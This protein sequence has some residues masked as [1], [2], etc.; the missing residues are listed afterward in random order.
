MNRCSILCIALVTLTLTMPL[1]A[2]RKVIDGRLIQ[3]D[4]VAEMPPHEHFRLG[5]EA[6]DHQNWEVAANQ[7]HVIASNFPHSTYGQDANYYLGVALYNLSEFDLANDSLNQYLSC[8]TNPRFFQEAVEYKFFVAEQ[9]RCGARRHFLGTKQLPK[10]ASGKKMAIDIYDEVIA[11]LPSHEIAAKALFSKACLLW[12]QNDYR[13]SVEAFQTVIRR[14]PK[15][16]LAP[17]SY[18]LVNKIY[19]EQCQ[20]EY[21]NPDLLAFSQ[22]NLRRFEEDFPREER[23]VEARRDVLTIKEKYAKGLYDIGQFYER[24]YQPNAAVIYYQKAM[25]DFPDTTISQI[26]RNRLSRLCPSI[27]ENEEIE[28]VQKEPAT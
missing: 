25:L 28:C 9:F 20:R 10:W 21:Q 24:V 26:C 16:E 1:E 13:D 3:E 6:L 27:F 15:H 7:F 14:F 12:H 18:L 19:L 2:S 23:L 4:N 22:I 11:A 5:K 8:Q 17:E